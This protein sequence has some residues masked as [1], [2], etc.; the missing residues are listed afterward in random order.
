MPRKITKVSKKVS[1]KSMRHTSSPKGREISLWKKLLISVGLSL[2]LIVPLLTLAD[3]TTRAVLGAAVHIKASTSTLVQPTPTQ[4]P[5]P[6]DIH[7]IK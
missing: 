6:P 5:P 3:T 1:V 7:V 4:T 2:I